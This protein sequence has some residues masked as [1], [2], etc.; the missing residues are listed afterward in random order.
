MMVIYRKPG[1]I[2]VGSSISLISYFSVALMGAFVK[3]IPPA[4]GMGKIIFFQY[5]ISL[6][7]TLPFVL[8]KGVSI[9]KTSRLSAH[10]F[11]DIVGVATFGLFFLSLASISLTNAVVLRSTTPFWIPII[12]LLWRQ[13]PIPWP[14]WIAIIIGFLGVLLVVNPSSSGYF[15]LGT[16]YALGSGL[17]MAL[18]ALSIRRLSATE[19]PERTLFY[20]CLIA[21]VIS[22]PFALSQWELFEPSVWALLIGIG[23]LMFIIQW[24]LIIAFQ[25]AKAS[26]L[27]P[28]SYTAIAFSAFFDWLLWHKTPGLSSGIG[29]LVIMG[30]GIAAILLEKKTEVS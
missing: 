13:E 1:Q 12:L 26:R 15:S 18:A 16:L 25:Y 20:Y 28:I 19:P 9:L 8:V 11:R 4:V 10:L 30:S 2:A 23:I 6:L 3:L 7:C 27:A 24:T 17:L 29:I 21:T 22:L 14:L 5:L